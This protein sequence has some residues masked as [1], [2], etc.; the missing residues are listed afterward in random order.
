MPKTT[1]SS[2]LSLAAL[3]LGP[4]LH[5]QTPPAT[6]ALPTV[7]KVLSDLQEDPELRNTL[8]GFSLLDDKGNVV[9][10]HNAEL[11][12]IPASTLKTITTATALEILGPDFTFPTELRATAPI[13][14]DGTLP[15][16]IIIKGGGDPTLAMRHLRAWVKELKKQGLKKITGRVIGD[17]TFFPETIAGDFWDWSD[18][19][20]GY[21]A[22]AAGLNLNHNRYTAHF[23][24]GPKVVEP[25]RF[26]NT[27]PELPNVTFTNR[28]T[29]SSPKSGDQVSVFGGPF[30]T[31]IHFHGTIPL[32]STDFP[33]DGAIPDPALFTAHHLDRL[34]RS[35]GITTDVKPT[36]SY[37]R[38]TP[39]AHLLHT[40]LSEPLSKIIPHIH[41]VS[42]NH[43]A[44]CLYRLLGVKANR[45]ATDAILAHWKSRKLELPSLRLVDGSG[46]GR[47]N[48]IS[49]HD[50]ARL[51]LVIRQGPHGDFY[52]Q[53]LVAGMD[54]QLRYK[55][56][57]MSGIHTFTGFVKSQSGPEYSFAL[58]F[59][60]AHDRHSS[61][62]WSNKLLRAVT[63]L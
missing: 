63:A 47:A 38:T 4:L 35:A 60:H 16:N 33:I 40:H 9:A 2:L 41:D 59:N 13:D 18:V 8:V 3:T 5:A 17:A 50:L 57:A 12:L 30:A 32:G 10:S 56:G 23:Q 52:R 45:P 11:S 6:P 15:G 34:L 58:L 43:E 21:G 26:L 27:T 1:T 46:L 55:S 48:T 49:A 31:V 51:Q 37:H 44:E 53:S 54:G 62:T 22:S 24:A 28:V 39:A 42:D 19:G 29:T 14:D 36:A 61:T 7:G 25:A 20:S